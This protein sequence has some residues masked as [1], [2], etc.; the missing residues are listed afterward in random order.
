MTRIGIFYLAVVLLAG[1]GLSDPTLAGSYALDRGSSED[2]NQA[3]DAAIRN[4]NFVTRP[5]ARGRLRKTN[6]AYERIVLAFTPESAQIT[7]GPGG[8][9]VLPA[10]G[11]PVKWNRNGE[12]L[13]VS[14]RLQNGAYV[15]TF[16]AKDGRR[17]NAFSSLPDGRLA[18]NVTVTSPRLAQPVRYRLVYRRL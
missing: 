7:A 4:M 8:A 14:G 17:T 3:I 9:L 5:I 2:V 11:A 18:L 12:V 6:P 16:D 13:N 15:E 1:P 10:S